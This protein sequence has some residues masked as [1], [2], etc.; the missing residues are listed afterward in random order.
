MGSL[1]FTKLVDESIWKSDM[2]FADE[3]SF[4]IGT[5]NEYL[6]IKLPEGPISMLK[7]T[8]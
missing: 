5:S 8:A 1:L 3:S 4:F 6:L 2:T 7:F